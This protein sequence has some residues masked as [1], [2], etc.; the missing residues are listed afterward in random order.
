MKVRTLEAIPTPLGEILA[1]RIVSIPDH[2][3]ERLRGKVE[4]VPVLPPGMSP[5]H[6]CKGVDYW[7]AGTER[8]PHWICRKC[9]PPAQGAER[10]AV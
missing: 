9:H 8:Y 3:L 5:C 1:G 7:L 2:L 6:C 4:P 10:Q